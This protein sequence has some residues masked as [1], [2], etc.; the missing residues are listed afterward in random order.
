MET[1]LQTL[2]RG[3]ASSG[4]EVRVVCVNHA[5]SPR[6][7]EDSDGSVRVTRVGRRASVKGLDVCPGLLQVY[8]DLF[9]SPPDVLHLH[10]PNPT[11]LLPLTL[12]KLRCALVITHHSDIVRQQLLKHAH[13]PFELAVYKRATAVLA[14]SENY[15]K[16]SELLA[17]FRD[18]TC[19]FPM[20]LDLK[21]FTSPCESARTHEREY[22]ARFP[23]PLWLC[24]GRLVYYKG[25]SIAIDAL[26]DVPGHLVVVGT[27]PMEAD[28]RA[29]AQRNGVADR[30]IWRGKTS[31]EE[32]VGAYHAATALWFPSLV[33]SEAFGL[34]QVEAMAA[35]CPVLNS[36]IPWSGVTW[37]CRHEETGL[38]SP[39]GDPTALASAARRLLEEPLLRSRLAAAAVRRAKDDF[40]HQT[41]T[42][43]CFDVYHRVLERRRDMLQPVNAE[44]LNDNGSL[45]WGRH[46]RAHA[47][48]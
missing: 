37:V 16:G 45:A 13:H 23:G 29:R 6:T 28:L 40:D 30:V 35:G 2:A 14:T 26:K 4:A 24:V 9:R 42:R 12:F 41:M 32:L 44:H 1:H 18:K 17:R 47:A 36:A 19:V 15:A 3:Q 21:P 43:R 25:V 34:V 22:R 11:M 10:T 48:V 31:T 39:V 7:A 33:R 46:A 8:R 27:G 5:R 20:G 38:T